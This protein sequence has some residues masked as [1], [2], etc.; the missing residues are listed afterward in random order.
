MNFEGMTL[1]EAAASLGKSRGVAKNWLGDRGYRLAYGSNRLRRV[2]PAQEVQDEIQRRISMLPPSGPC[3]R[4]GAR[5][6]CKH[7]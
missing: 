5:E 4:C 1:A 7:R 3:F 6:G 2:R